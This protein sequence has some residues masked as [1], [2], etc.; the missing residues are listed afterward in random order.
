MHRIN[1]FHPMCRFSPDLLPSDPCMELVCVN[2]QPLQ[3]QRVSRWLVTMEKQTQWTDQQAGKADLS[4]A[5]MY[6]NFREKYLNK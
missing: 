2:E 6:E 4:K 3:K 5:E 1:T